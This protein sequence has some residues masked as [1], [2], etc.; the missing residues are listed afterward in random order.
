MGVYFGGV[1]RTVPE[2]L[3]NIADINIRF[4][5]R[6]RKGMPEDMRRDMQVQ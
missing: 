6:G 1:D 5:K 3:L 4:Q 2:D